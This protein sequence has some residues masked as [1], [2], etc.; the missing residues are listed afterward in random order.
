MRAV[1]FSDRPREYKEVD[2]K[3]KYSLSVLEHRAFTGH[4]LCPWK[5]I[6][7]RLTFRVSLFQT[8]TKSCKPIMLT[9]LSP[10][11]ASIPVPAKL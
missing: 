5:E 2:L 7:L 8:G 9:A 10:I 4:K 11:M 1:P 6:Y 3:L